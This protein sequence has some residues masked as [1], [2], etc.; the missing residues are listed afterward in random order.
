M[1]I[2]NLPSRL[3]KCHPHTY[4]CSMCNE[5]SNHTERLG[6]LGGSFNPVHLGHLA[7]AH[8]AEQTWNL[9][10][11][12]FMP[13]HIQPHKS[14]SVLAEAHHRL[15][16]L[17]EALRPEPTFS[18]CT[19]EL[20]RGGTS[21]AF[22]SVMLLRDRYPH[23]EICFIIGGDTLPELHKWYRIHALLACC[24]FLTLARPGAD[25]RDM[26][27][28]SLR[29]PPEETGKL[30]ENVETRTL[31]DISASHIRRSIAQGQPIRYL[32]PECVEVYI[33]SHNLYRAINHGGESHQPAA[34]S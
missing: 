17:E 20:D 12:L 29:L 25:P 33:Q 21:Y 10:R 11:V 2:Y 24:T 1:L 7:I 28:A 19:I 5:P 32:V 18:V 8:Q 3:E 22:D 6:I 30:L 27:P 23:A 26:D 13:C 31:M 15:A 14:A 9:N 4:S 16:M 34:T